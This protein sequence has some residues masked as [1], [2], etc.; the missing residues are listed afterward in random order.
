MEKARVLV[1]G[2][3]VPELSA[4]FFT[5]VAASAAKTP[6]ARTASPTR[7]RRAARCSTASDNA[8]EE[9]AQGIAFSGIDNRAVGDSQTLRHWITPPGAIGNHTTIESGQAQNV[10]VNTSLPSPISR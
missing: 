9:D 6:A 4:F 3:V 1:S 5:S 10:S 2:V 7:T 8:L